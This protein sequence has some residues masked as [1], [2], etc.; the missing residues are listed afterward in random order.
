MRHRIVITLMLFCATAQAWAQPPLNVVHPLPPQTPPWITGYKVRWP[1]RVLGEPGQQSAQS[2]I[3][4]LPT[5]GWLRPDASDLAVQTGSGKVL[6]LT[7][8]S[9]DPAADTIIQFKRHG[10]DAWYWVY[11]INP[12]GGG[13]K[14]D[15]KTDPAFREGITLEV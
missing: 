8:L 15:V 10:N 1:V 12:Q 7:V 3:V 9:H 14:A 13:V 11:G 6:P 5:G 2:V 4:D